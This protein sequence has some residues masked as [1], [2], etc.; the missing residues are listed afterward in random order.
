MTREEQL[1]NIR[2][3]YFSSQYKVYAGR[4][5]DDYE[6]FSLLTLE[7]KNIESIKRLQEWGYIPGKNISLKL[8]SGRYLKFVWFLSHDYIE[9]ENEEND[10]YMFIYTTD[11]IENE[12]EMM[13]VAKENPIVQEHLLDFDDENEDLLDPWNCYLYGEFV[14]DL[15]SKEN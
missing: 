9:T 4:D 2:Q 14:F 15:E 10:S 1:D 3:L 7:E 13:I 8:D 6:K 11:D 12:Q 5:I